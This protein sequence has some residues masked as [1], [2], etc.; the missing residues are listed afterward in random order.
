MVAADVDV[1]PVEDNKAV[2]RRR[3]LMMVMLAINTA[4]KPL[5]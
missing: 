4:P 2:T 5:T 3:R 1:G